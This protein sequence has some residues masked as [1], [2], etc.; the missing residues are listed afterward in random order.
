MNEGRSSFIVHHSSFIIQKGMTSTATPAP[1]AGGTG[2]LS[3]R[4]YRGK[5]RGPSA[6]VWAIARSGLVGIL[7]R[8]LFWGLFAAAVLIFL[9]FF[10]SLYLMSWVQSQATEQSVP[11]MGGQ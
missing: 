5:S 10:F 2:L 4:A 11:F 9:F 1:V 6:A 3:Y 8:K 7:R